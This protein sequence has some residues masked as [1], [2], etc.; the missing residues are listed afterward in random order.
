MENSSLLKCVVKGVAIWHGGSRNNARTSSF[1]QHSANCNGVEGP[2]RRT[3]L[4]R[5]DLLAP[6]DLQTR[7]REKNETK[8]KTW[9]MAWPDCSFRTTILLP[10][11]NILTTM[12]R[13]LPDA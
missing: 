9:L 10:Y 4:F 6:A 8:K 13:P 2:L 5:N 7:E 1:W 12:A 3:P 11:N